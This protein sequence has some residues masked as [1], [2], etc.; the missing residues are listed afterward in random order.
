MSYFFWK[1]KILFFFLVLCFSLKSHSQNKLPEKN[2]PSFFQNVRYGGSV[3][4]SF[5]NNFFNAHIAPKAV[6]DFNRFFSLGIGVAGSYSD[7]SNF[8][9]YTL[10]GGSIA[11]FRPLPMLQ[12]SSEFEENYVNKRLELE[13]ADI[14]RSY[15]YPALFLGAGYTTGNVTVGLKYDVLYDDQKSIYAS[16][17]MPFVSIFF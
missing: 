5:S 12:L 13:G 16:A 14:T 10:G 1:P 15:W 4:L 11:L 8:S 2:E 6:Y 9:A 17:L 7:A 3:G